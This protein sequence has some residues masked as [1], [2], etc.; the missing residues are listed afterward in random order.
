MTDQAQPHHETVGQIGERELIRRIRPWLTS[1]PDPT[2]PVPPGD[3]CAEIQIP[4]GH[5]VS[6]TDLLVENV[7]FLRTAAT[8]W[9]ALGRKS[10]GA[11][12]SDLAAAGAQPHALLIGLSLPPDLLVSHVEQIYQGLH[13]TATAAQAKI[14]GGDTTRGDHLVISVT[15]LGY[16][17]PAWATCLRSDA[18]PGDTLYLTGPLGASRAA[19]QLLLNESLKIKIHSTISDAL[20]QRHY[21]PPLRTH[22]GMALSKTGQRTAL[23][24]ISD[25]LYNEATLLAEASAV[26]MEIDLDQI[27]IHPSAHEFCRHL[28]I[29]PFQFALFSGEEYELMISSPQPF[30]NLQKLLHAAGADCTLTPIGHVHPGSGIILKRH[31]Q[32]E[33]ISNETFDHF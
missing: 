7:H 4:A 12:L 19:V 20:L 16:K 33:N 8:P 24:D 13:E 31:G 27:P 30:Q 11:N 25:S 14:I 21:T 9:R 6:T 15:A 29:D 17:H 32:P 2:I 22:V 28:N 23:I 26:Q 1:V 3:D 18:R 10:A 5:L